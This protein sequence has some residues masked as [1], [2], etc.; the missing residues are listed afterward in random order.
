MAK[1]KSVQVEDPALNPNQKIERKKISELKVNPL[2]AE[3]YPDED[4]E[5]LKESILNNN[6]KILVPLV[7]TPDG[8]II[9][10]HRRYKAAIT[11]ARSPRPRSGSW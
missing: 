1:K 10:G 6:G 11:Y 8:V 3:I 9:S 7:I 5:D 4:I 2:N